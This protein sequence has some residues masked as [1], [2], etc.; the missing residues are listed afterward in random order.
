MRI[1]AKI[2]TRMATIQPITMPIMAPVLSCILLHEY[3]L[4]E[5][6]PPPDEEY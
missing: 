3:E 1:M 5:L 4:H 2:I 6:E